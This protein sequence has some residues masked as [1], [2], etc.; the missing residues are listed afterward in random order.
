VL[1]RHTDRV[2][3]DRRFDG[4]RVRSLDE[5]PELLAHTG[6]LIA[7][8]T[9]PHCL[10]GEADLD[11]MPEGALAV[12][13]GA[14]SLVASSRDGRVTVLRLADLAGRD[15]DRD[16]VAAAEAVVAEELER[17]VHRIERPTIVL[18]A[19]GAGE[20]SP[21]NALVLEEARRL[22][23]CLRTSLGRDAVVP[24]FRLGTP[25]FTDVRGIAGRFPVTVIPM[26]TSDGYFVREVLPRALAD[27]HGQLPPQLRITRPVGAVRRL[28][29]RVRDAAVEATVETEAS[30]VL[31][32]GHGTRRSITSAA[33][34][35]SLAGAIRHE[36]RRRGEGAAV[37]AAFLDQAP[38][39]DEVMERLAVGRIVVV[40][41]LIG[42]GDHHLNDVG[43]RMVGQDAIV[44]PALGTSNELH[45]AILALARWH[46]PGRTLRIGTRASRLALRQA[47]LAV[48]ALEACGYATRIVE[49]STVGDRDLSRTIESFSIEQGVEG[50]FTD[51]LER[52]LADDRID[53]AVHSLKDL[54]LTHGAPSQGTMI[55]AYLARGPADESLVT[56]DGRPLAALPRGAAIGTSSVRRTAQLAALRPDL[57]AV[58]L[59]G[60]VDARIAA[61]ANG[62][63]D[64]AILATAGLARLD[65][66]DRVAERWPIDRFVPEAGQGAIALTVR[67]DD[68]PARDACTLVDDGGTRR[69]V[70][71][72]RRIAAEVESPEADRRWLA[73]VHAAPSGAGLAVRIRLIARRSGALRDIGLAGDDGD[74]LVAEAIEL[75]GSE[76]RTMEA[77]A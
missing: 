56:A 18:A 72:E 2:R 70:D 74:A 11:R 8:T 54:P 3:A 49:C 37:E 6:I 47:E 38:H 23:G 61:V 33:A 30:A 4:A 1:T 76:R 64:G 7:A 48:A 57:R 68:Q 58:P 65:A 20:G 66:L 31:V 41:F 29:D 45:E 53:I 21:A 28:L 16:A 10:I 13:L 32:I 25:G 39:I 36:L 26:M 52:A 42:G 46:A 73:G 69:A 43:H 35:E 71:V 15:C 50:P 63:M 40:P 77:Y 67:S 14:P 17:G 22:S 12:D 75:L 60:A 55:A 44:L 24:A 5:L 51:E 62:A 59:R 34:T 19:H 27:D 9:S